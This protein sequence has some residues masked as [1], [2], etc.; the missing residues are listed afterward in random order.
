MVNA[1]SERNKEKL[2]TSV[3]LTM[4]STGIFRDFSR[5]QF[6][7]GRDKEIVYATGIDYGGQ[8]YPF[9]VGETE[10]HVGRIGDYLAANFY[11]PT[12]F[13]VGEAIR[14]LHSKGYVIGFRY[15]PSQR[16]KEEQNQFVKQVNNSATQPKLLNRK[17][18]YNYQTIPKSMIERFKEKQR[19]EI[20]RFIDRF[21][22]T[23]NLPSECPQ[24]AP[25]AP[26]PEG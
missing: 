21:L 10:R 11:A 9:Y 6:P 26:S 23:A 12:D 18:G 15:K 14:Y 19:K 13:R 17:L 7:V 8:F 20:H 16:R 3:R 2:P 24:E 25:N 1:D 22:S 5:F 4:A